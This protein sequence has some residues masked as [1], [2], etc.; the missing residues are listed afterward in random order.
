MYQIAQNFTLRIIL[1]FTVCAALLLPGVPLLVSEASQGPSTAHNARP[2]HKKPEGTFP[3]LEDV[4]NESNVVREGPPP[5]PSTRRSKRNEGKPWDGRRVG[6]PEPPPPGQQDHAEKQTRRAHAR[7]RVTPP[8]AVPDDQFVQNFFTWALVRSAN[9]NE[10]TYWYD[11]LRAGYGQ[12][13]ESLK[14]AAIE[15]GRT[16][17]ESAEYAARN[18]DNHWYVYDLYK[19]YLMRDPDAGGWASWEA[20]VAT[21][22]REYVRRGFEESTEFATL[23]AGMTPNGSVTSAAASLISARVDS[24]NQPGVGMLTRDARWSVPLLSLPGRA[25]LDL[26][27]VLSYSSLVW[28]RSGPYIYF[29]EDNGF[30]SPGFRLGFPTIQRKAFDVQ[31]AR[32]A[33]LLITAG[34]QRVELRQVGTSNTYDAADS[35][36]LR[37]TDNGTLALRSTDGARLSFTYFNGEYHC[38]EIKDR[39]GNYISVNYNSLGQI[40]NITDTL[41]R[42]INFNYDGD[43]NLV[44]ITQ[45]WNGQPAHQWVSFG[46]STRNMQSSFTAAAVVGTT[47]GALLPVVTQVALNDTSRFTFDYTNS[48]QVSVIRNYFGEAERSAI[49]FGYET[50][51]GDAPRLFSSSVSAQNW[52]GVNGVPAQITTQYSVAVDGACVMTAPDGTIYKDYYGTGWQKGLKTL[53]EIWSGGVR[54]KWTTT[55]WTQDN[56]A[57]SYE[58]NPRVT[59]T[60][61]YDSGGNRRRTQIGYTSYNLPDAI[62]LPTEVKEYAADGTTVIRR[63]TTS[64]FDGGQAYLDRRVLGL[65]REVILY[66]GNNQ[67]QAKVWYD[68]DWANDDYWAPLPQPA[69][70]HDASGTASGRGNLCWTGRWDVTDVNNF[71]KTTRSYVKYNR[72]GS[73]IKTEDHFGH[74]NAISYTDSFSDAIIRNTFAYPTTLTDADGNSSTVQ[75]NYDFGATTRTQSPTPANQTQGAVQTMT[76]NN[77]GQLE[78]ITTTNN[79]AYKRFWYGSNYV[80]SYATVNNVA[81]EAYSVQYFDGTG[82]TVSTI[83]NHPGSTGGYRLL[84]S[85]YDQMGRV[86]LQSNPTEVNSSF[87]A[88]GDDSAGIYYTQQ[89]YDWKGRPLVTTNPDS[90]TRTASYS[91]CGCAG[92]E[93]VTL[94]DEVGRR[95]KIYSDVLGRQAKMEILNWN[96]SLYS[97]RTNTYNVRDQVTSVKQYQGLETSGVY[98]EMTKSYDGYGRLVTSKDPIQTSNTVITYT[99]NGQPQTVTDARG[100]TQTFTYNNRNLPTTVSYSNGPALSAVT[101]TYDG[102]GNRTLMTDGTGSTTYH[103][104]QLSQLTSETRQF[105]GLSGSFTLSYEYNAAG[106][107]KSI[108]DHTGSRVDY[109]YNTAGALTTVNGSG[110]A[111]APTY[112]SNIAYRAS[113]AIRDLDFGNGAHQ[114]LNFNSLLRNTSLTLSKS[115]VNAS[116]NYEYYADGKLKKITDSNNAIFD[117][118]FDYDHIGRLQEARTGSEARGGN[119][120]DGPFKQTYSYDVWENTTG[121]TSRVWTETPQTQNVSFTNNRR[122][123]WSYDNEGHL[124]SD[125]QALYN[126]DAA[127]RPREFKANTYVGGWPTSYPTQSVQE[128]SQTFDGNSAPV[129][130]TTINRW[131]ELVGEEIQVQQ[132]TTSTYFLRSTVLGGKVVAELSET[133]TKQLG[134]VFADEMRI[135]T[136]YI[137]LSGSDVGWTSTSPA[138][139]SEYMTDMFL[140]R[141]ELDPLGTDVTYAPQP[142]LISEPIFYNPKFDRMPLEIEG[143]PS[144][145]YQQANQAW[146]D[147]MAEAFQAFQDRARAEQLWQSG[148]RSE[149]MAILMKNPN[150]GIEYRAVYKNEVIKHGSYFGQDAADFLYGINIAVDMGLL[151]TVAGKS[152]GTPEKPRIGSDVLKAYRARI[153][154]MLKNEKCLKYIQDLLDEAKR[155]TGKPY[156]DILTTFDAMRFYWE[157]ADGAHGGHAYW[158]E[159]GTVKA[160]SISDTIITEKTGGSRENQL[161]RRGLL[162]SQTTQAFL[163]ETLHHVSQSGR[164]YGDGEMA[165]ALN[166]ILVR[167]GL[168]T[169]QVFSEATDKDLENSSRYW[170]LK[171]ES[172]CPAPRK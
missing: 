54:Q 76:Y 46:W 132:S 57:V 36:Y 56:T 12:G 59:E 94:T 149:A 92:G 73:V 91:G 103:Y 75:Y 17:F 113:G 104:N 114:H 50:P 72:T 9:S 32:N 3:D 105:S 65:L 145:E 151:A 1:S 22:G 2:R 123:Y 8:P 84:N 21:N 155:Q 16:L 35:S 37:L 137:Y 70:Q 140:A 15:L 67:P 64:Y 44:S 45:V 163:G 28:T 102:A 109:L 122:Q 161:D 90:T 98:Q 111:S 162:I 26:G 138:T 157:K 143:G 168:D 99:V 41:S 27:L 81:D 112:L 126:Y 129:K 61:V 40:T 74:G 165:N 119:T 7:R 5:I 13:Q 18:R 106:A 68:Y 166:S 164:M 39:N 150:V 48:L 51:A 24:R 127:G 128:V 69:T 160:A 117:R 93:V 108:T 125:L 33:Y 146:A 47:N 172:A 55:A 171:V 63:T 60:N 97:T 100:V 20:T 142:D 110:A 14:L 89:T 6:D 52:T 49:S 87:V 144:A 133:G 101:F 66:D 25:G 58:T 154:T 147:L 30:P 82:R 120:A 88:A 134:Y 159:L 71:D 124:T 131:E 42:V 29:D 170:H 167:Q 80:A 95:Q 31:T 153:E 34:G 130:K 62:A 85:I 10:T 135:A 152:A 11:Q 78:R 158:E 19:T 139:G 136:Q 38:T 23:L 116:W 107:L 169:P 115:S 148:K 43:A 141:K 121:L 83:S 86:S 156:G 4:K 96:G 77:L 79:G 118:A 53:S